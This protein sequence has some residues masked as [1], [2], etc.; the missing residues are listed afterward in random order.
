MRWP[1]IQFVI[2][3]AYRDFE[4]AKAAMQQH[5]KN[6]VLKPV[7][8]EE[9]YSTLKDIVK[10]LKIN[11][12]ESKIERSAFLSAAQHTI[13]HNLFLRLVTHGIESTAQLEAGLLEAQLPITLAKQPCLLFQM[14]LDGYDVFIE[15]VWKHDK[16]MLYTAID[17]LIPFKLESVYIVGVKYLYD[18]IE[19]LAICRNAAPAFDETADIIM[20]KISASIKDNL[21]L[22]NQIKKLRFLPSLDELAG[23]ERQTSPI[24]DSIVSNAM[25]YV[26]AHISEPI[27]LLEIA[28]AMH[29]NAA[30]FGTLFKKKIG[31]SFT[32]YINRTK[33]EKS[34]EYLR[35]PELS[36]SEISEMLGYRSEAYYYER[37]K[38]HYKMT[39]SQYRKNIIQK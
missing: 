29:F 20:Q 30:Y 39:P 32:D 12:I 15:N 7:K 4:F 21:G 18:T 10:T 16:H 11:A 14:H 35:D 25:E 37:F 24:N 34:I 8:Y 6:Y 1:Q 3:S 26:N 36:I 19:L 33:M 17:N 22:D 27:T 2:L 9:L 23:G 31:M 13:M 28:K 5:V 38:K